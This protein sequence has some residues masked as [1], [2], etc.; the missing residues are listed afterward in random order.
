VTFAVGQIYGPQAAVVDAAATTFDPVGRSYTASKPHPEPIAIAILTG[1]DLRKI[2]TRPPC[3]VR[4]RRNRYGP[5]DTILK[6]IGLIAPGYWVLT[7][8]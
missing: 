2:L 6:Q 1:H 8:S 7:P 5:R 3:V 4:L